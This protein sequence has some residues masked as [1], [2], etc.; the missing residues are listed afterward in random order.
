MDGQAAE[1]ARLL[2][3]GAP[4]EHK[5]GDRQWTPLIVA[6]ARGKYN[7]VVILLVNGGANLEACDIRGSTALMWAS[8]DGHLALVKLLSDKGASIN[9][10]DGDG[11]DALLLAA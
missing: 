4:T 10:R 11:G 2:A 9:A 1:V 8:V 6:A 7:E 5:G 3:L